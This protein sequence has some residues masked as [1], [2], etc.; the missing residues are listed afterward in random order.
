VAAHWR[1]YRL[2]E[3]E[4]CDLARMQTLSVDEVDLA[5]LALNAIEDARIRARKKP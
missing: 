1:C 3:A 4:W 5:N 2:V